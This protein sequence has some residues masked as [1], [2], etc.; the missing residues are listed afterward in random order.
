MRFLAL[1]SL[2][3]A[4]SGG[5]DTADT[6]TDDTAS[7]SSFDGY[8]VADIV[9]TDSGR[10]TYFQSTPSL[11]GSLDNSSAVE[12]AGNAE[13]AAVGG[14]VF[15]SDT[16]APV[17]YRYSVDAD[18]T[19]TSA[20]E[21]SFAAYGWSNID[22]YNVFVSESLALSVNTGQGEGIWWDP[23]TLTILDT[24]DMTQIL[25]PSYSVELFAPTLIGDRIY[26]PVR[27]ADWTNYVIKHE[28]RVMVIDTTAQ[29]IIADFADDR[30]PSSGS[31]LLSTDGLAYTMSDGRNYSAQMIARAAGADEIPVN[32]FLRFD[33]NDLDAGFQSDWSLD[34][35]SLT[36]GRE[37]V[38]NL[39]SGQP[40]S[41]VGFAQVMYEEEIDGK[42]V[43]FSFW[44]QPFSKVWRF[45]LTTSP[46][47]AAVVEGAPFT[48]IGFGGVTVE[49]ALL[50]GL[51]D[52]GASSQVLR[53]DPDTNAATELFEIEGYFYQAFRL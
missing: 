22:Y 13:V 6:E 9:I 49:G 3:V 46:P 41:G 36:D 17:W 25:D 8:I 39:A 42:P 47:S 30:C 40:T 24:L 1:L 10:T 12:L 7:P 5:K 2:L 31:V 51:S 45:D 26:L 19:I 11:S 4:C 50:M 29:E 32:C 52:D 35:P 34:V 18:G 48:G 23:S 27:H 15:G 37:V 43:D 14:Y 33:P 16:E 20:G 44:S 28:T 38:T 53:F 21:I